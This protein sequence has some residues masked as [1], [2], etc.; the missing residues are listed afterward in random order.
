MRKQQEK[1]FFGEAYWI[2]SDSDND[3]GYGNM[4]NMANSGDESP[5]T[6]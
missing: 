1:S 2:D 5:S 6:S 3:Q 4:E